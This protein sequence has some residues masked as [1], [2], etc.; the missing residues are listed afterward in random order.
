[1]AKKKKTKKSKKSNGN[2][3][4]SGVKPVSGFSN[5]PQGTYEGYIKPGSAL[6]EPKQDG[7]GYRAV[8]TFIVSSPEEYENRSQRYSQDLT[9]DFGKGLFLGMLETLGFNPEIETDEEAADILSQT[10]NIPIRFWVGEEKDEFPPRVSINERLEDEDAEDTED[11]DVEDVEDEDEDEDEEVEYT[12]KDIR[13]M[14]DK[15]I[16]ELAGELD[17]DPDDYETYKELRDVIC[18]ELGL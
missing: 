9:S 3:L 14:S 16:D 5:L 8:M 11:E 12:K 17:L 13:K 1:M 4:F 10:D 18:D 7:S 2:K 15:D 6:L